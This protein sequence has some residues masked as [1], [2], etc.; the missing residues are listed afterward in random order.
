MTIRQFAKFP[1]FSYWHLS[2]SDQPPY[3]VR[4]CHRVKTL[5]APIAMARNSKSTFFKAC[6]NQFTAIFF[7]HNKTNLGF[8]QSVNGFWTRRK[9]PLSWITRLTRPLVIKKT[10][11][12][13]CSK[14]LGWKSRITGQRISLQPQGGPSQSRA[15][16]QLADHSCATSS[17]S[18]Q[19]S[20]QLEFLEPAPRAI[21]NSQSKLQSWILE[22]SCLLAL[23]SECFLTT[24]PDLKP[25][26]S[27]PRFFFPSNYLRAAKATRWCSSDG[28]GALTGPRIW[29]HEQH[30]YGS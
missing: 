18:K 7:D 22:N 16:S 10:N 25:S 24:P 8:T 9:T 13:L 17:P 20:S 19:K 4:M 15:N 29:E 27:Q 3:V 14:W 6:S 2:F 30:S 23:T 5:S 26:T 11:L 21:L 1:S 12:T 28:R